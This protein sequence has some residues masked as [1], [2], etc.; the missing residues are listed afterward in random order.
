MNNKVAKK[1]RKYYRS[2][3]KVQ[4]I[5][6]INEWMEIQKRK[7]NLWRNLFYVSIVV[8]LITLSIGWFI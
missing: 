7:V 3:A 5:R 8:M 2:A 1:I 4:G 6:D